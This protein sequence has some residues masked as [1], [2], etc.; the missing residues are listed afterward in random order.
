MRIWLLA[1]YMCLPAALLSQNLTQVRA[2]VAAL[3]DSVL[4]GRGYVHDGS[5]RAAHYLEERFKQLGLR[6]VQGTYTQPF[7]LEV[8]VY[9]RPS[10]LIVDGKALREGHD[11]I[12]DPNTGISAGAYR[13]QHLDSSHFQSDTPIRLKRNRLPVVYMAGIDSPDEVARLHSFQ[14]EVL[15]QAPMIKVL[16]QKLTWGIGRRMH[17]YPVLEVRAPAFPERA[18]KATLS[19]APEMRTYEARNVLGMLP[20]KRSDSA[21]VITAHYDHLGRMGSALFAGASDNASGTSTMLDLAAYFADNDPPFDLYFIAFAGEEA[22]LIGSHHFVKNPMLPLEK[23]RFLV[24]LDLMGSAA[25]GISIVNGTLYE[26]VK[27]F[28]AINQAEQLVPKIRLRGKAANSDHY[29]F[30]EAG[31]P[32]IFIYTE[33][34][35]TAYHDVHDLPTVLDWTN[36]EGLFKLIATFIESF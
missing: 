7:T 34:N 14:Q 1:T 22:G 20:G 35:V 10:S 19:V 29:H 15:T 3:S 27:R 31:V 9:E 17:R 21:L 18:R 24:N 23:M 12:A 8:N 25:T 11:F 13:L 16:P 6:P 2:D 5:N 28:G 30:A 33:G 32:A 4:H 36:Y 26:E